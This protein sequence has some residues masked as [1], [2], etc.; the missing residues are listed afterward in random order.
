M[1]ELGEYACEAREILTLIERLLPS[2]GI[3]LQ[4]QS[5]QHS[6]HS[7]HKLLKQEPLFSRL[8]RSLDHEHID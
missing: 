6:Q 8:R 1:P 2:C 7:G 4:H 5:E 3:L